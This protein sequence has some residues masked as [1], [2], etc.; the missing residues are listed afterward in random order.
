MGRFVEP[1]MTRARQGPDF[2]DPRASE[3]PASALSLGEDSEQAT[4]TAQPL[5]LLG[6]QALA[7][8]LVEAPRVERADDL[9]ESEP[10]DS[11]AREAGESQLA[12]ESEQAGDPRHASAKPGAVTGR[13]AAVVKMGTTIKHYEVIHLGAYK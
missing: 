4:A 3:R 6:A 2:I 9:G 13:R 12:T 5:E 8:E 10:F 7:R 1:T 11:L